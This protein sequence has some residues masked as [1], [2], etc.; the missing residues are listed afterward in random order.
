MPH[1]ISETDDLN[2]NSSWQLRSDWQ[3]GLSS[4]VNR[5]LIVDDSPVMRRQIRAILERDPDLRICGEAENGVEAVKQVQEYRPDLVVLDLRMPLMNGLAATREIKRLAPE[6]AV[7][8]FTLYDCP[9]IELESTRAG[10]DA[11]VAKTAASTQL[12]KVIHALLE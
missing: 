9:Q 11:L 10:A 2:D 8:L 7:L 3:Q 12:P 5:I 4:M 6:V 1:R